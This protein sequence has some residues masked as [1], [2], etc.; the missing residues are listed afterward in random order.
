[1]PAM[2]Q[3]MMHADGGRLPGMGT[4]GDYGNSAGTSQAF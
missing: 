2:A 1:M 3:L 4:G